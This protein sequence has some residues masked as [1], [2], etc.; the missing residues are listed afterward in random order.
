MD[1]IYVEVC[2]YLLP[3]FLLP[4]WNIDVVP[5]DKWPSVNHKATSYYA[6]EGGM[7]REKKPDFLRESLS[8]AI[9]VLPPSRIIVI[10]EKE[11][12]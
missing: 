12:I 3:S 4:V 2:L 11:V 10:W 5:G 9:S 1:E 6:E 8:C 7:K